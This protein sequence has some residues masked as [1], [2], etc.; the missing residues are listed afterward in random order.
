VTDGGNYIF[1]CRFQRIDNP[2][3]L[4]RRLGERAGIVES[5]LFV[6]IATLALVAAGGE[7]R[8]VES[9]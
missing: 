3:E 7:V 8:R 6:G 9:R 1:D 4:E 5:G 2:I